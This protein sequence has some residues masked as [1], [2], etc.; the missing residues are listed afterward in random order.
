[1]PRVPTYD[2][3]QEQLRALPGVRESSVASPS[4]F[5]VAAEQ[6]IAS[7]QGMMQAGTGIAAAANVMQDRE[8][9]DMLFRAETALKDEYLKHEQA[10]RERKGQGAWGATVDTEKW[11]AEQEKKHSGVLTND[12][13]RRL[14][15]QSLTKMRQ[16]SLSTIS[17]YESGERRRSLE[18]SAQASIVGS[19]NMAAAAAAQGLP[20]GG[21]QPG[22]V[23]QTTDENGNPVATAPPVEVVNNPLT[24]IKSDIL[25]RVQVLTD[26]NGW[27]PERKQLEE[28][29]YLTMMHKQVIQSLAT[30]QPAQAREYYEANKEEIDGGE[31]DGI[32]KFVK[33]GTLRELSQEATDELIA[34]GMPLE[35]ALKEV[36]SRYKGDEE[37]E[38]AR[39]VKERYGE[40]QTALKLGQQQAADA[41]WKTITGG[42]GRKSIPLDTW[43]AMG[44]EEQRQVLDYLDAKTRRAQSDGKGMKDDIG[45]L[46]TVERMIESGDIT[47]HGQLARYEPYFSKSTLRTLSNK[48]EKR[49]TVPPAELRRVFEERKGEKVNL[50]KM[51]DADRAEW[52]AFQNYVLNNV[53]ETKRP[54]DIDAWADRWFLK[55][56]GKDDSMLTNDPGTYGEAVTEGRKDFVISTPPEQRA[57]VDSSLEILQRNGVQIPKDRGLARD[58]FYTKH[59]L[60][61]DRWAGAHGVQSSP[62]LTAAYTLLKQNKKPVTPANL[63]YII[64]QLK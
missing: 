15:S 13:Q 56:Y 23:E 63:Q 24:G 59:A 60:E 47:E 40:A 31:R 3:P 5:G 44:G 34:K 27:S 12:V 28:G 51:G 9:A 8:N 37:D 6:R 20:K 45:N 7:A 55:G 1:M 50:G 26:I 17:Q 39:R 52:M 61:A 64:E 2:N 53:K 18:E 29:K 21:A 16:A 58:E 10:V 19:I 32:E 11:F 36:R 25:K 33:E 14:F 4:L 38:I 22:T 49:G 42:G 35:D 54:E 62:E 57:Q 30:N 46:D 48:I 43:N 41:A